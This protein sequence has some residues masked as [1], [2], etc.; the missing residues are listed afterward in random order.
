MS[1]TLQ[2]VSTV[3]SAV[4]DFFESVVSTPIFSIPVFASAL[5]LCVWFPLCFVLKGREK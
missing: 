3:L 5:V 1:D 2:F 4:L